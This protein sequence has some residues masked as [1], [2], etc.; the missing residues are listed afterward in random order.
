MPF[1]HKPC[2]LFACSLE[3]PRCLSLFFCYYFRLS[4]LVFTIC[5]LLMEVSLFPTTS[6]TW[7]LSCSHL[8]VVFT[9]FSHFSF[10]LL[11]TLFLYR[12]W[13][14]IAPRLERRMCVMI[15]SW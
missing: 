3:I 11:F 6:D 12:G 2:S 8:L 10:L 7:F 5:V 1:F 14:R 13:S 15:C 4:S 9:I